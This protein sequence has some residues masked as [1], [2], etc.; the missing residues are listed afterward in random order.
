MASEEHMRDKLGRKITKGKTIPRRA[1]MDV[2]DRLKDGDDAQ[3]D[4]TA[5]KGMKGPAAQYMNQSIFSMITAAGSKADLQSRFDEE[6]SGSEGESGEEGQAHALFSSMSQ[7]KSHAD[8]SP[9]TKTSKHRQLIPENR[10]LRSL[11]KLHLRRPKGKDQ[12]EEGEGNG[13]SSSQILPPRRS[14]DEL[15]KPTP[16]GAPV[17]SRMLEARAKVEAS[18]HEHDASRPREETLDGTSRVK[19]PVSLAQRLMEI[20]EFNIPEEVLSGLSLES[21]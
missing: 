17:M 1:S 21:S 15:F 14:E 13:M 6:S 8:K 20:F 10:L 3:E 11:P 2:P 16:S 19:A 9:E 5:P 7:D 4:V 18:E 12:A